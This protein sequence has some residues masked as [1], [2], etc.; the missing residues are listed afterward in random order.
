MTGYTSRVTVDI[1]S[2]VR[3]PRIRVLRAERALERAG[4]DVHVAVS[5]SGQG[6]HVVGMFER[7]VSPYEQVQMRRT[8]ADDPNRIKM[9]I[10]RM[11]KG[12]P[13]QTMWTDKGTRDGTRQVFDCADDAIEYVERT[14]MS[15]YARAKSLQNH[16]HKALRDGEIAH[17]PTN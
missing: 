5:S 3:T 6:Y 7:H 1:D 8:L 16:G 9:D 2:H 11:Q 15:D 10:Q 13:S 4:A 12:L 17:M 14:R